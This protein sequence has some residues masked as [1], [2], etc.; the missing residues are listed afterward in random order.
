MVQGGRWR[1]AAPPLLPIRIEVVAA[2]FIQLITSLFMHTCSA[3]LVHMKAGISVPMLCIVD[4]PLVSR[5]D[6][7]P[8][9]GVL[10]CLLFCHS[11]KRFLS[12]RRLVFYAE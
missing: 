4:K 2:L 1:Q 6:S 8:M 11:L 5:P 10:L 3:G 12:F 9:Q 7:A